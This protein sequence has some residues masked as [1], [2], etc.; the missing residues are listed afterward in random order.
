MKPYKHVSSEDRCVLKAY[1][2]EGKSYRWIA[3]R[4][5]HSISTISE[6]IKAGSKSG[7]REDYDPYA[8]HIQSTLR[9]VSA[10]RSNP[11]KSDEVRQYVIEKLQQKEWS[12][13]EISHRMAYDYPKDED[14]RISHETIYQFVNSAQGRAL[15][16]IGSLRR[17]KP[18]RERR[19][20]RLKPSR[21]TQGLGKVP[22]IDQ[23]PKAVSG[24]SR[25][26]DWET[27]SMLGKKKKG[28]ILSVQHE[29]KARYTVF[30]KCKD[31]SARETRKAI[32]SQLERFPKSLRRTLT[33][34]RGTEGAEYSHIAEKLDLETYFCDAYASW[35]KGSVENCIGLI[36]Q[37][38]PK[39]T[40]LETITEAQLK[41]IQDK[42][43]H[44]P[45][46]CLGWKTPHE[47]LSA[48][49][50]RLGVRLPT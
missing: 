11:L 33:F 8:A 41:V 7:L 16:L 24:R 20:Y 22:G 21:G 3:P 31:K 34:D 13:E 28:A 23:R 10:N 4:W 1:L 43:N 26:G 9:K 30:K 6:E 45:R 47:V 25:F 36:R 17:G 46:K 2:K 48:H 42:L 29:R 44:R 5:G 19:R 50:K 35:Q 12:P 37:Y 38:I 27:D 49:C 14:M 15:G 32:N 39:G 40:L 18:R